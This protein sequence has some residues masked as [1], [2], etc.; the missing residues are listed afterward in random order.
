MTAGDGL[1]GGGTIAST[2]TFSVDSASFAPFFSSSLN[3]FT[4]AGNISASGNI[5]SSG[6]YTM[7][8][9][10]ASGTIEASS[11]KGQRIVLAHQSQIIVSPIGDRFYYG[12]GSQGFFHHQ[13]TG[14]ITADTPIGEKLAQ[15]GQHNAIIL[16]CDIYDI[17]LRGS[18]RTNVDNTGFAF[19]IMKSDRAGKATANPELEFVASASVDGTFIG[20][21]DNRFHTCDITGSHTFIT[22]CSASEEQQLVILFQPYG[23]GTHSSANLK[24]YWTL[25]AR[26]KE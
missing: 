5:T 24:Y 23:S 25:S 2:R 10:S 3:D 8:S 4:T 6:L 14:N 11:F 7:G 9:I 13:H 12:N 19:W 15:G 22:N 21:Q 20:T 16:P 18:C 26:T 17:E 1:T